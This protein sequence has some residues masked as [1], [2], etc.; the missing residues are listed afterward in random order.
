MDNLRRCD[1]LKGDC[2]KHPG[3]FTGLGYG[4]I[5]VNRRQWLAHRWAFHQANGPIPDGVVIRHTCDN[6]WCINPAH[7]VAG[8]QS[9]NMLDRLKRAPRN[10]QTKLWPE[11]VLQIRELLAYG[12][13]RREIEA[14]YGLSYESIRLIQIRKNWAHI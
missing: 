9:Q 1:G 10:N 12:F 11:E 14:I 3:A 8:S 13:S 6:R 5:Y 2:I 4:S 7:L